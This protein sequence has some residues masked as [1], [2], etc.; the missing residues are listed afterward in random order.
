MSYGILLLRGVL[1]AIMAA[2][3]AQKLFGWFG[4]GG[5]SQTAGGF[6]QL[7]FRPPLL[8]AL[9][10]GLAEF[11]G[12]TLLAAGL[13][14]PLATLAIAVVML[15]A[16]ATVHW[17]NGFWVMKGGYEFNLL[18]LAASVSLA[19]T[20]PGRFSL[21]ALIGWADDISG[22]S[23]G[24]AVAGLSALVAALTL[25]LGRRSPSGAGPSAADA[26]RAEP[27]AD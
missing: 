9:A 11:G 25:T 18:I 17:R 20:G 23:W 22:L 4:G 12:G 7:G 26:A 24:F 5:P 6:A 16:I 15:N 2:H 10:A 1:G 3:G 13:V 21:D 8:A 14:T 19:A 27:P